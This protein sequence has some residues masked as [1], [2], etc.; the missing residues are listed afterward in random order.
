[1]RRFSFMLHPDYH[2]YLQVIAMRH[3]VSVSEMARHAIDK[4]ITSEARSIAREL[5][6]QQAWQETSAVDEAKERE[7]N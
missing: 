1:M 6:Q 4:L 2:I 7:D 3:R 5:C